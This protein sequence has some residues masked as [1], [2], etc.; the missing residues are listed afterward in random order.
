MLLLRVWRWEILLDYRVSPECNP[1]YLIRVGQREIGTHGRGGGSVATQT[2]QSAVATG[3]G[4]LAATR[5][6][7]RDQ[8]QGSPPE[9]L[10]GVR[11]VN[12]L[13]WAR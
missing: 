4:M 2:E 9:P 10:E 12:T 5:E 11:P 6:A 13:I 1:T 8:K 3:E 7:G